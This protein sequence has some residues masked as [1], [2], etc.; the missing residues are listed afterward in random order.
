MYASLHS[1][2]G[3]LVN[4]RQYFN[5]AQFQS[6]WQQTENVNKKIMSFQ[7]WGVF[8]RIQWDCLREMRWTTYSRMCCIVGKL[9]I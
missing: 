2:L 4:I 6:V 5:L 3:S 1:V 7:R 8:L 9:V